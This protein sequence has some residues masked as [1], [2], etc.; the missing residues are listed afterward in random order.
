MAAVSKDD[1]S[2]SMA[3]RRSPGSEQGKKARVFW[4]RRGQER[5]E[6]GRIFSQTDLKWI[7]K[8]L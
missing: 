5:R 6:D 3:A 7:P 2:R 8:F 1:F 4:G